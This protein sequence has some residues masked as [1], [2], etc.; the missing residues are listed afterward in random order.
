MKTKK[1][2]DVK[3]AVRQWTEAQYRE[4]LEATKD[5]EVVDEEMWRAGNRASP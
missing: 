5:F 3:S 1:R 4:F 2:R